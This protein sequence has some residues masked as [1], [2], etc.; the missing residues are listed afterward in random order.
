MVKRIFL[1][2]ILFFI[3]LTICFFITSETLKNINSGKDINVLIIFKDVSNVDKKDIKIKI[4]VAKYNF[5]DKYIKIAF[6]DENIT[7]IQK[8]K[9]SKTLKEMITEIEDNKQVDFIKKEIENI[10]ED[11]FKFDFYI[12]FDDKSS[13]KLIEIVS[14]KKDIE[15]NMVLLSKCL[16]SDIDRDNR[17]IALI[18]LLNY[19]YSNSGRIV[20]I[21]L[22]K[23]LYNKN[24]SV[25]TN[26]KTKDLF[27]LYSKIFNG[28]KIIKYADIPTIYRRNR[29][30]ID[31]NG[32]QKIIDFF[33]KEEYEKEKNDLKIEILNSTNKPRLAIKAA[34]KLR[35]NN[36]DVVDWGSSL[37][38][39]E[40]TMIFDLVNSFEKIKEI[41][42]ILNCGEIVLRPN[43]RPLTDVSVLLGQ[44][45]S[46]YDKL[47]RQ[48]EE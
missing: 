46:I 36:F 28:D 16:N 14:K 21:N 25:E 26:F 32:M 8:T 30:E 41:K 29:I 6:I 13:E 15:E 22:L 3:V 23:C 43:D 5:F 7:I 44:D 12:L 20:L 33:D 19:I 34:N 35:E 42:R 38:K 1:I 40:F 11:K 17:I 24:F 10:F 4:L 45:C 2:I 18:K 39:Y 9:K 48:S 31:I 47:D 27:L 37:K